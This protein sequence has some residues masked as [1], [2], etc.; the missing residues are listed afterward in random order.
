MLAGTEPHT[1]A[2][3]AVPPTSSQLPGKGPGRHGR[4]APLGHEPPSFASWSRHTARTSSARETASAVARVSSASWPTTS[5]A[6]GGPDEADVTTLSREGAAEDGRGAT[7]RRA[8]QGE[9]RERV[10]TDAVAEEVDA[11][12]AADVIATVSGTRLGDVASSGRRRVQTRHRSPEG[13][14]RAGSIRVDGTSAT[15]RNPLY[16]VPPRVTSIFEAKALSA[17][18]GQTRR[19]ARRACHAR[20][21]APDTPLAGARGRDRRRAMAR[22]ALP[23]PLS[24]RHTPCRSLGRSEKGSKRAS[25]PRDHPQGSC[26]RVTPRWC[27]RCSSR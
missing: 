7:R 3:S 26:W 12:A 27:W 13:D 2:S 25:L 24:P 18:R 17:S 4:R 6:G 23:D 11:A 1:A 16:S 14:S 22:C 15:V 19:R 10:A 21:H 20:P 8:H 5:A 9:P